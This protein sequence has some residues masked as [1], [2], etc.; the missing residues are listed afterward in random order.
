MATR[1]CANG[2]QSVDT[3]VYR[4]AR[5]ANTD[6]VV[7]YETTVVVH[8]LDDVSRRVEARDD[9]GDLLRN[10]D[11]H[12]REE[13]FVAGV[14]DLVDGKWRHGVTG[15]RLAVSRDLVLDLPNPVD[16]QFLWPCVQRGKR[17]DYAGF[18]LRGHELRV[19]HDEHRCTDERQAQLAVEGFG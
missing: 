1:A 6:D 10:T 5:V 15:M 9:D 4:L 3:L 11:L 12:V 2:D 7:E 16:K 13:S 19:R 14:R 18:A 8:C 17:P